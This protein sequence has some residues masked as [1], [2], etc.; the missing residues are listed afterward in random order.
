[1]KIN[2][3][4]KNQSGGITSGQISGSPPPKRPWWK[5]AFEGAA[6]NVIFA[7]LLA[8]PNIDLEEIKCK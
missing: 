3:S 6:G 7:V 2:V 5:A 1:M 4:S 8:G